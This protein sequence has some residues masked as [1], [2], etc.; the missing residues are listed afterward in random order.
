MEENSL[1][2]HLFLTL[3]RREFGVFLGDD[4]IEGALAAKNCIR[5]YD[6]W[7]DFYDTT[8]WERDNPECADPEYLTARRICRE[9]HGKV[10]YFSWIEWEATS[11]G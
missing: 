10:W 2:R 5:V 4:D 9:I 8:G 6:T 7:Q 11:I 1:E 3:L